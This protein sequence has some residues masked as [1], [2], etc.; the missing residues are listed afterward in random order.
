MAWFGACIL[1]LGIG[2]YFFL[3]A[4]SKSIKKTL[5]SINQNAQ[6][7]TD[8]SF[9]W[10]RLDEFFEFHSKVEQFSIQILFKYL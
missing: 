3:V 10:E 7:Q 1:M 6:D 2:V 4:L 9:I 5:F 8:Q